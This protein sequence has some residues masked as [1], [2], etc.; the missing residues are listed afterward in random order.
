MPDM[1]QSGTAWLKATMKA[2]ASQAIVYSRQGTGSVAIAQ[3]VLG[4]TGFRTDDRQQGRSRLVYADA[5][6]LI[7][8]A[9]LVIA[10]VPITPKKG[11][12]IAWNG[13][14]YEVQPYNGEPE[15]RWDTAYK[16]WFR[17]HAKFVS[18]I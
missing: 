1:L 11:D 18:A 16:N 15:E 2:S 8:P 10:G 6:F 7:D 14:T 3:A 12:R 4:R 13:S 5:D 17:V 9:D